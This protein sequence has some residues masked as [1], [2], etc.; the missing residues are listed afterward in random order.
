MKMLFENHSFATSR[1]MEF[2]D[3]TDD[4]VDTVDRSGIQN[5]MALVFSPH[6]TC[7][8]LINERERGFIEDFG[9]LME[10]L[11]PLKG[12]YRHDDLD[13]EHEPPLAARLGAGG[14]RQQRLHRE[15]RQRV[16]AHVG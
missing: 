7:A 12:N 14:F 5:G 6:T 15:P 2:R 8:V 16:A 11:V 3:M 13:G 9:G 10:S 1:C 4:V